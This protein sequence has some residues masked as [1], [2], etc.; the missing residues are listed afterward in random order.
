MKKADKAKKPSKSG[1]SV[2]ERDKKRYD[3]QKRAA[4]QRAAEMNKAK[5]AEMMKDEKKKEPIDVQGQ[6]KAK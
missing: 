4:D 2:V 1:S 3:A 6:T 5:K